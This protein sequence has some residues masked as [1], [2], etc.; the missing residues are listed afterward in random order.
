MCRRYEAFG[1]EPSLSRGF[2]FDFPERG[3][4]YC[5]GTIGRIR[6]EGC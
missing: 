3:K 2:V 4:S 6:A 1:S 5:V